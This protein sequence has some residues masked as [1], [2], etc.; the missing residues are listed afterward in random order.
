[1]SEPTK[2]RFTV[3]LEEIDRQLRGSATPSAA[4]WPVEPVEP[5]AVPTGNVGLQNDPLAEL[6]RI[7]GQEDPFQSI[8]AQPIAPQRGNRQP[9]PYAAPHQPVYEAAPPPARSPEVDALAELLRSEPLQRAGADMFDRNPAATNPNYPSYSR[10]AHEIE[11]FQALPEDLDQ[12]APPPEAAY[13]QVEHAPQQGGYDNYNPSYN[14]PKLGYSPDYTNFDEDYDRSVPKSRK[15]LFMYGGVAAACL[16]IGVTAYG[17]MRTG[18]IGGS[19]EVPLV[20]ASTEP[21]KVPPEVPGGKEFPDQNKQIYERHNIEG[22]TQIVNR[23]EQ[24]VDVQQAARGIS[25]SSARNDYGE[26][27]KIRTVAVGPDGAV[28]GGD[29]SRSAPPKPSP[30]PAAVRPVS[31]GASPHTQAV[32]STPAVPTET[33]SATTTPPEPVEQSV[34]APAPPRRPASLAATTSDT[35][36]ATTAPQRTAA[37]QPAS[38]AQAQPA[39]APAGAGGGF[40]VQFGVSGTEAEGVAK[41]RRLQN[42][43]PDLMGDVGGSVRPAEV[44]GKTIFRVR[45]APMSKEASDTLCS[46]LKAAGADCYVA[47]N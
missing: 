31:N 14:D 37:A 15:K 13:S 29:A 12:Y 3:D 11:Q 35:A 32:Q 27:R 1:M 2:P 5:V 19:G 28:L 24:P 43:H 42:Q 38:A 22:K 16:L 10:Q 4:S 44:N 45:S 21:T 25:G 8:L 6:A 26:P 9:D 18:G 36:A 39:A 7:V 34:A 40:V 47:R 41:F 30:E 23:E 46:K 17:F 33:P 20:T